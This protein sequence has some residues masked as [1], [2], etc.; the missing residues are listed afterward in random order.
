MV[1]GAAAAALLLTGGIAATTADAGETPDIPGFPGFALPFFGWGADDSGADSASDDD[2]AWAGDDS[3]DQADSSGAGDSLGSGSAFGSGDNQDHLSGTADQPVTADDDRKPAAG[4][5]AAPGSATAHQAPAGVGPIAPAADGDPVRERPAPQRRPA[6][7]AGDSHDS[8]DSQASPG[9]SGFSA[10]RPAAGTGLVAAAKREV[11]AAD[12]SASP[13]APFQQQILALINQNRRRGGCDSVSLDRRL[14]DAANEHAAD[15][16]R[17]RYFAHESPNGDGAGD[18]VR[19]NGY[20]WKRYGENIARG[21][22]SPYE[23]VDG[24]MHSPEHRENI[25]DC[26]LEQMGVG[27]AISD[28]TPYWVQDFATPMT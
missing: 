13:G 18:R 3:A 26:R 6:T 11:T 9:F 20:K 7:A 4:D 24:W 21:A 16:A 28:D 14:I 8:H 25:M 5:A 27:L 10:Q 17:R 22:D 12:V 2:P 1:V 15:M 23:V 19:D